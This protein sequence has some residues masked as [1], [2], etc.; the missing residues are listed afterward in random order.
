MP[1]E[2]ISNF[3][4]V[5]FNSQIFIDAFRIKWQYDAESRCWR[6]IGTV[7]EIPMASEVQSGLLSRRFKQILDSIPEKGGHFGIIA[8]P[9]LSVT[10]QEIQIKIQDVVFSAI[11]TESGSSVYGD[12]PTKKQLYIP[13]AFIGCFL[14]FTKGALKDRTFLVYSNDET[15]FQLDGDASAA[16]FN[17]QFIVFDPLQANEH[18]TIMGDVELIS[19]TLDITCIDGTGR[20]FTA[21]KDCKLDY[22]N[23]D[24]STHVPGLDIKVGVKILDSF[25]VE[26]RSCKGPRGNQGEKG[27]TGKDGTGDGPVGEQ[28]DPG[29]DAPTVGHKFTGIKIIDLEDVYDMAVINLELDAESGKLNVVKAKVSVPDDDTPA[30]QVIASPIERSI[31]WKD[32]E[33][34]YE[35][36][37]PAADPIESDN[38]DITMA[39]LPRGYEI[40]TNGLPDDIATARVTQFNSIRLGQLLDVV[41]NYFKQRGIEINNEYNKQIKAFIEDKDSKA[42]I[43]LANLA[44]ELA[45]C[46]WQLPIEYCLGITPDDCRD[47]EDPSSGDGTKVPTEF[48]A[49]P[50]PNPEDIPE[51]PKTPYKTVPP[52][53]TPIP[54]PGNTPGITTVPSFPQPPTPTPTPMPPPPTPIPG[55]TVVYIAQLMWD[56][57]TTMPPNV[58]A[59][60]TYVDG[61]LRTNTSSFFVSPDAMSD[62]SGIIIYPY[63]DGF[64][65]TPHGFPS[66]NNYDPQDKNSV[67]AAYKSGGYDG[68]SYVVIPPG[69]TDLF[70]GITADGDLL[71]EH[72]VTLGFSLIFAKDTPPPGVKINLN[73]SVN[74][75]GGGGTTAPLVKSINPYTLPLSVLTPVELFGENFVVGPPSTTFNGQGL[76]T[77]TIVNVVVDSTTHATADITVT[78]GSPYDIVAINPDGTSAVGKG[79]LTG[80][81]TTAEKLPIITAV[82]PYLIPVFP[83]PPTAVEIFGD[84]FTIGGTNFLGQ[85]DGEVTITDINVDTT[86]HATAK[87]SVTVAVT[88]DIVAVN[89]DGSSGI[90]I[91]VITGT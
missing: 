33:Y 52:V 63:V 11:V 27:N 2:K 24:S 22:L 20:Q 51:I 68:K 43:I 72:F 14:K 58:G 83:F 38:A 81:P 12:K 45:E 75:T 6:R 53:P 50:Y 9:L 39:A 49:T 15:S 44:Q 91:D 48:N 70:I 35:I 55:P 34:H 61:A 26:L 73:T 23:S 80:E 37:K 32:D 36:M 56:G 67:I 16:S 90:G 74:E 57:K 88:Y 77:I 7:P 30:T 5:P 19:D 89:L 79:V 31:A 69:F 4:V 86:K 29:E 8:R 82:N 17:D 10:P 87:I 46:E 25:C 64:A 84:N 13:N 78:D 41:I 18:G 3:P 42:R 76:G 62:G 71:K 65:L 47:G 21:D 85:G 66:V 60:F 1:K 28:G 40:L 59:L 54:T